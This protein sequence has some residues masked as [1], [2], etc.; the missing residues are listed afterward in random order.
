[1]KKLLAVLLALALLSHRLLLQAAD[2]KTAEN[3]FFHNN[4]YNISKNAE[5]KEYKTCLISKVAVYGIA[6]Y[7]KV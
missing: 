6:C 4:I 7:I 5:C 3:T 2:K 1:M